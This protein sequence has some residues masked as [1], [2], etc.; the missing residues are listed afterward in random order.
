M[1][2][3][4][5]HRY[6]D[7]EIFETRRLVFQLYEY[8]EKNMCLVMGLIEKNLT[9][10]LLKGRKKLMYPNDA[11]NRW[12]GH[13]YHASQALFYIMDTNE[14]V[15]MSG[16]DYREKHWWLQHGEKILTAQRSNTCVDKVPPH[17]QGKSKWYGWKQRPQQISLELMKSIRSA[18]SNR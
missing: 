2:T 18:I 3:I 14:L 15:P 5:R 9:S 10:D 13:C 6:Q 7:R 12:Y 17:E 8:T 1:K 16:E 4:E 11:V